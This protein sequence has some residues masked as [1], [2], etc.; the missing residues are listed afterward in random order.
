[1]PFD[2]NRSKRRHFQDWRRYNTKGP[3]AHFISTWCEKI[4]PTPLQLANSIGCELFFT[5]E[6]L[7]VSIPEDVRAA[8]PDAINYTSSEVPSAQSNARS[9]TAEPLHA[10]LARRAFLRLDPVAA[11]YPR[12][13]GVPRS[14]LPG[15]ASL[16]SSGD[17]ET[18]SSYRKQ[19][20]SS[21]SN[22]I[23]PPQA[24]LVSY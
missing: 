17:F 7:S 19:T 13:L 5:N 6:A 18:I 24:V 14:E 22:M 2:Y 1:M 8:F 16:S 4:E 15:L 12:S 20:E 10:T 21:Q 9:A 23:R 11:P 3:V